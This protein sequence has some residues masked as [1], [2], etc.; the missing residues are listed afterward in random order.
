MNNSTTLEKLDTLI[1]DGTRRYFSMVPHLIDDSELTPYAFRLYCRFLRRAG[2]NG[3]C[4]E[5]TR[6]LAASCKMSIGQ[7]SA[8]KK[9]LVKANLI[10]IEYM[11]NP[12]GGDYHRITIVD[13]WGKN[14]RK[15]A[16]SNDETSCS[17]HEQPN[18]SCSPSELG[19]SP[20]ERKNNQLRINSENTEE[21]KTASSAAHLS[22]SPKTGERDVKRHPTIQAIKDITNYL[23]PK[24]LRQ[25]IID[26]L[27]DT[28][29]IERLK[30]C[31]ETWIA[32]GHK[33]TNYAWLF[34][35]Y[36][37]NMY[38]VP[39]TDKFFSNSTQTPQVNSLVDDIS[40][41]T[42]AEIHNIYFQST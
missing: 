42:R 9:E 24:G 25:R 21:N 38:Y 16:N 12:H 33:P 39:A 28:P 23:P 34:D 31:Y 3:A 20:G 22:R 13:V 4:W 37:T 27:G 14:V 17:P 15:Y 26:T 2:A 41:E 6:N 11:D 19:C 8:A 32:H 30:L 1:V 18:T 29:D 10:N 36:Q 35:W 40:A 7:V 5:N